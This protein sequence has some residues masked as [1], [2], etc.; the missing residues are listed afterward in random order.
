VHEI[1]AELARHIGPLSKVLVK[2]ARPLAASAEELREALAP[3]IQ[4]PKARELFLA[5]SVSSRTGPP[6]VS[7]KP[8]FSVPWGGGGASQ[9]MPRGNPASQPMA[10]SIP[11]SQ[12]VTSRPTTRPVDLPA[13]ELAAIEQTLSRYIGPMARIVVKKEVARAPSFRDLAQALAANVD[14]ADQREAFMAALHKALP[15]RAF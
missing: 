7:G 4:E 14:K 10:R 11:A 12:A 1:E 15:R 9:P 5:G 6:S 13:E 8:S 3:S 2:K